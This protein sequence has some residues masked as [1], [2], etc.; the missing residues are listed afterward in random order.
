MPGVP[1]QPGTTCSW[2]SRLGERTGDGVHQTWSVAALLVALVVGLAVFAGH[3]ARHRGTAHRASRTDALTGLANRVALEDAT[4]RALAAAAG[5]AAEGPALLLLDL[6]GFK[7]VNDSLGHAAG[8]AVLVQVADRLRTAVRP[9]DLVARLGGDEFAVLAPAPVDEAAATMLGK[10]VLAALGSGGFTAGPEVGLDI[11]A[12][13]GISTAPAGGRDVGELLRHADLAMYEAKRARAGVSHFS[14]AASDSPTEGH[15]R[16]NTLSLMRGAMEHDELLLHYQPVVDAATGALVSFEVLLRWEHPT[17]G[18]MQPA[19][20]LPSAER[21]SL[22]RPLTRWV[23]LG[24]TRQGARWLQAGLDV[25]LAVN[26]SATMLEAGL[27]GIIDEALARSRFPADHLVLE[28][29][30]SAVATSAE[31]ARS[32]LTALRGRGIGISIDDFGA[33][34]TGLSQLRGLDFTHL[35]VDRQFV[36]GLLH[37]QVDQAITATLIDLA[38]RL[39]T[40]VV[41]EGVEDEATATRLLELGCDHLQ[42]FWVGHPVTAVQAGAWVA[43]RALTAAARPGSV[44]PDEDQGAVVGLVGAH[45]VDHLGRGTAGPAPAAHG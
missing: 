45:R 14:P 16:L 28:I 8:D 12:S 19:E 24:A 30:E 29:T 3:L 42:G 17:R 22:I 4:R 34:Y 40:V 6:D 13:I 11:G 41:A 7:D 36:T 39:G 26:I 33:G 44:A 38:H 21:T 5:Q 35:K 2:A 31:E 18:M 15:D 20:F 27:V 37:D 1:R 43:E 10:T 9:G 25:G 32:V 23:L